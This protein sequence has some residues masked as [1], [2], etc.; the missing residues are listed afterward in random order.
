MENLE[1]SNLPTALYSNC[2]ICLK[3]GTLSFV[4]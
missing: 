1:A 3:I 4:I 2:F